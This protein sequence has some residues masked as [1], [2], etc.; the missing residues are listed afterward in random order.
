MKA[1]RSP[2]YFIVFQAIKYYEY[3]PELNFGLFC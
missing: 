2:Q 3:A 1:D